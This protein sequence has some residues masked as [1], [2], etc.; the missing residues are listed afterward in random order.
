MSKKRKQSI[1]QTPYLAE[2]STWKFSLSQFTGK[3]IVDVLGYPAD[4]FGGAPL[5]HITHVV[6]EDKS[7][8]LVEGEHDVPYIPAYGKLQNMD[9]ETLQRFIE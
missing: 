2:G 7:E 5:F 1:D 4:P 3:K 8:V 6:F 9:E